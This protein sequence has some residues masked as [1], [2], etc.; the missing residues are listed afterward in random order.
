MYTEIV[1]P[2]ATLGRIDTPEAQ[3]YIKEAL[4][5][6]SVHEMARDFG[7]NAPAPA[8][9][10]GYDFDLKGTP[11]IAY[12]VHPREALDFYPD[13]LKPVAEQYL[14]REFGTLDPYIGLNPAL[15]EM[16]R[17]IG[18][19]FGTAV[20]EHEKGHGAQP[21]GKFVL[22][23]I[24]A[25]TP[26]GEIPLGEMIV[27]GMVE[28][29][30]ERRGKKPPSRYFDEIEGEG[31]ATYSQY[32]N[33]VYEME[34]KSPGI[35]RQIMRAATRGGPNAA[36]RLIQS[37]PDMDKIIAKYSWNLNNRRN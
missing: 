8:K 17:K 16:D 23:S 29:A 37:V 14:K 28:Y 24:Y 11:V 6:R 7:N 2:A 5:P 36:I 15:P 34:G 10:A 35:T 12:Y 4:D 21:K 19:G 18:K 22:K 13:H 9:S 33:F 31:K 3:K 27:E 32:R 30:L 26:F 20:L 1:M 25:R